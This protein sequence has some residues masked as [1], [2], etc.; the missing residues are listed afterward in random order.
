MAYDPVEAKARREARYA[1]MSDQEIAADIERYEAD[2][3][4]LRAAEEKDQADMARL[5]AQ[6]SQRALMVAELLRS[7]EG[8]HSREIQLKTN[9]VRYL[10]EEQER[11][12]P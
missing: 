1:A 11:R 12:R 10:R 5:E 8:R 2:I 9:S 4:R 3:A 6:S 7:A